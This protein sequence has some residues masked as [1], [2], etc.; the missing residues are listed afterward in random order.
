M[1]KGTA[2][3]FI[4]SSMF[5]KIFVWVIVATSKALVD[6]G[7]QRSPIY[8]P[9]K[10]APPAYTAGICIL[11]VM[12]MQITPMVAAVPKEVPMSIEMKPHNKKTDVSIKAG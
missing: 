7:E 11:L 4:M 9:A 6:I 2:L 8:T 10:I 1:S 12:V 5:L 3:V